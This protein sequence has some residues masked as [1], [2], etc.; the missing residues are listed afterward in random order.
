MLK[1]SSRIAG[2][3]PAVLAVLALAEPAAAVGRYSA[4]IV[5]P[6]RGAK[7]QSRQ[8][9]IAKV[10]T[11]GQPIVLVRADQP[12]SQW[13]VQQPIEITG[14]QTFKAELRFGNERTPNGTRFFVVVLLAQTEEDVAGLMPEVPLEELPVGI[15]SSAEVSVVFERKEMADALPDLILEPRP[16]AIVPIV[17]E[18]RGKVVDEGVPI[19]LVR[20]ALPN[21]PWWIQAPAEIN[22]DQFKAQ[23]RFGNDMT[24]PGTKFR[25]TVIMAR[26][27]RH[28]ESYQVG[29]T[30]AE[31]PDDLTRSEAVE[32]TLGEPD[33]ESFP[34]EEP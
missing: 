26:N 25:T 15:P 18:V 21:S 19:V 12:G 6:T 33:P 3:F 34:E 7:V 9:L 4:V 30:L 8:E 28:A 2:L 10:L 31:L 23:V 22:G 24:L 27:A 5:A 29:G 1:L 16:N 11:P 14:P 20:A 17:A 13:W 32:V